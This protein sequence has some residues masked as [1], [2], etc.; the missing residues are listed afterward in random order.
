MP[1]QGLKKERWTL[2]FDRDLKKRLQKEAAQIGIYPVQLLETLVRD[3]LNPYGFKAIRD[4]VD[5]V[6]SVRKQSRQ[7]SDKAF[8]RELRQW[9]K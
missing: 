7:Q 8:L 4:S 1:P 6:N 2:T 3:K 9:Q 5:Y